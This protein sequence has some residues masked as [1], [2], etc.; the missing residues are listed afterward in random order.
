[1]KRKPSPAK[2]FVVDLEAVKTLAEDESLEKAEDSNEEYAPVLRTP[3]FFRKL[4]GYSVYHKDSS[5]AF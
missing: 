3:N 1:M 2:R 4:Y 5:S